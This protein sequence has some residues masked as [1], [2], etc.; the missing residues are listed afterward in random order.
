MYC[1]QSGCRVSD[2]TRTQSTIIKNIMATNL[3]IHIKVEFPL[4]EGI[5]LQWLQAY[6]PS[7]G[8]NCARHEGQ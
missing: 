8:C 4:N 7:C 2:G 1:S 5:D 3:Q 6:N